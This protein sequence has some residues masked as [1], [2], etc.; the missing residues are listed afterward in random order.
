M[1][2]ENKN[3]VQ[4][5]MDNTEVMRA[6]DAIETKV[7]RILSLL[8]SCE[9]KAE[10]PKCLNH[11]FNSSYIIIKGQKIE[12]IRAIYLAPNFTDAN[13]KDGYVI[14]DKYDEETDSIIENCI[15]FFDDVDVD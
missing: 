10:Q 8:G 4:V 11:I 3:V 12:R 15:L 7:N 13:K 2:E 14:Y 5:T 9:D 6:I 1:N